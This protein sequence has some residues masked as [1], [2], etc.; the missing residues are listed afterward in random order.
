MKLKHLFVVS[1][2]RWKQWNWASSIATWWQCELYVF[3]VCI[4]LIQ[5]SE[6]F[7]GKYIY[8]T[9]ECINNLWLITTGKRH[10]TSQWRE[11]HIILIIFCVWH[12]KTNN[13]REVREKKLF[14]IQFSEEMVI[15]LYESIRER[16]LLIDES[17]FY[18]G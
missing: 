6:Y 10:F 1:I 12:I 3:D 7:A 13:V 14:R 4:R 8:C 16:C 2:W 18:C 17:P 15:Y 5:I 9:L 11:L